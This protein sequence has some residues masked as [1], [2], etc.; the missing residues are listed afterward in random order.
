MKN[1]ECMTIDNRYDA[2]N[3]NASTEKRTRQI[4]NSRSRRIK[5][6]IT[7]AILKMIGLG[8]LC[9]ACALEPAYGNIT[10]N[11]LYGACGIGLVII[12]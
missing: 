5:R 3:W 1:L 8:L 11:A 10:V 7:H 4:I 6:L 2:R 12:G 9:A